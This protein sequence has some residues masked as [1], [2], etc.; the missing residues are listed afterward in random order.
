[1]YNHA[2]L[3]VESNSIGVATLAKLKDMKYPNLYYQTNLQKLENEEGD[4]P[5]FKTSV[6]TKPAIIGNLKNALKN[7]EIKIHDDELIKELKSYI[8][9]DS[10]KL[11]AMQGSHDDM[12]MA[13]AICMEGYRTHQHR[14]TAH[15]QG[16]QQTSAKPDTTVWM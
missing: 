7:L 13:L 6:S 3:V 11:E 8:L 14:L 10:G 16:F 12:V 2:L 5:G 1:M 9:T 4:R 15:R